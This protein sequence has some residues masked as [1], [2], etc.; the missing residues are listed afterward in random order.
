M[1]PK[2]IAYIKYGSFSLVN[3]YI[4]ELLINNFP[5]F[6]IDEIDVGTKIV[7]SKSI[8]NLF[9]IIKNYGFDILSRKKDI[10]YAFVRNPYFFYKVKTFIKNYL[11]T[12]DYVFSFQTQSLFDASKKE[13][14]HFVYTDHTH[15]ALLKYPIIDK[16]KFFPEWVLL[17]KEIY[18]NATIIFTTSNFASK[19]LIEDYSCNSKKVSCV[20]SGVNVNSNFKPGQ[21]N[22]NRKN[23]LFVGTNWELKGGPELVKAYKL[24][25]KSHPDA[26]LTIIGCKPNIELPNC[27]VIG[28]IPSKNLSQ[29]YEKATI[30]CLPSR[31]DRSPVAVVEAAANGL[32]V[33]STDIG[34][35]SDRVVDVE[36]GYLI[37]PGDIEELTKALKN[38]LD[39]PDKCRIL[40]EKGYHLAMERFVWDKVGY[41][42]REAIIP[43]IK[44]RL[45]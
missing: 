30:F 29:Y 6:M 28:Y 22:Y 25:L 3:N 23:I 44:S 19:S 27:E 7:K 8:G 5:G 1:K 21:K 4:K 17:E 9:S 10:H 26:R 43:Q 39:S 40:G 35:I 16:K 37:K 11:T 24:I 14:P 15:L 36:T 12:N 45:E 18:N 38:L 34:G 13:L 31:L 2:K 20:Y 32:P 42:I 33:I 41:K